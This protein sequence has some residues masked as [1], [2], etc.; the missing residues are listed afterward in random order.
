MAD[1]IFEEIKELTLHGL[2]ELNV[3]GAAISVVKDGEILFAEGF[4]YADK[5]S[6]IPMTGEHVLPIASSSKAFTATCAAIL[7]G[8]GK[9]DF[10]KPVREYMPDFGLYD[11]VASNAVTA[12]DLLCHR[13]GMPRHDLLWINWEDISRDDLVFRRL[14]HLPNNK[15]FR[16][17]WQYQNFM[18]AAAGCLVERITGKKWEEFVR[19]RIFSPLGMTSSSFGQE[20]KN[21]DLLYSVLYKPDK[22]GENRECKPESVEAIGPAGSIRSTARDM[23]NW[24]KFNLAGGKFGDNAILSEKTFP[25]LQK[26]NIPYDLFPFSVAEVQQIGYGMGWFI[27]SFRGERRVEHGGNLSGATILISMLPER[28]IGCAILTNADSSTLTYALACSIYDIFLGRAGEKDWI[29]FYKE[30]LDEM[31]KQSDAGIEKF[32]SGKVPDKP[33]LHEGREYAGVYT[34]PGYGDLSVMFDES[35]ADMEKCL[36]MDFH[37]NMFPLTH[38][39]YDIFYVSMHDMPL[40]ASFKTGVDGGV[41][42]LSVQ[43]EPGMEEFITF[44]RVQD[45]TERKT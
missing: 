38:M 18:Y 28:N 27:D 33:M 44:K 9:L 14:R 32:Y 25:E 35:A 26:P 36:T 17:V 5:D 3:E 43:F 7:A 40:A 12:R 16:S 45:E 2:K 30:K 10:D 21:P 13:T 42:S 29:A 23:A 31:K 34:H 22:D 37:N 19:E 39:H 6:Q 41:E 11:P 8:E 24:L 4:G 20:P 15:S 1:N